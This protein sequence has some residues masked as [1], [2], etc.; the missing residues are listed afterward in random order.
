MGSEFLPLHFNPRFSSNFINGRI[1]NADS[2]R[3]PLLSI[4]KSQLNQLK[5]SKT[6]KLIDTKS[7]KIDSLGVL[8]SINEKKHQDDKHTNSNK[9][10]NKL[11]QSSYKSLPITTPEIKPH[12][13]TLNDE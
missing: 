11:Q 12:E 9:T 13:K 2:T 1:E 6:Q 8:S 4:T 7:V 5:H 3:P 10:V